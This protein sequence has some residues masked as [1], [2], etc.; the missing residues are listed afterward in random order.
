MKTTYVWCTLSRLVTST[1]KNC[2]FM[3]LSHW[4]K[5][6]W[7]AISQMNHND[8]QSLLRLKGINCQCEKTSVIDSNLGHQAV[9]KC[10]IAGIVFLLCRYHEEY[11]LPVFAGISDS[12]RDGYGNTDFAETGWLN[13][14]KTTIPWS[15]PAVH[16]NWLVWSCFTFL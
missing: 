13:G 10:W 14:F 4:Q 15:S 12:S 1:G 11:F 16:L 2:M 5:F 6:I 3:S 8:H 9:M 7:G